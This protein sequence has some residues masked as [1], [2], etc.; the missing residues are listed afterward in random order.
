[1]GE[2]SPPYRLAESDP[3]N[4]VPTSAPVG[5]DRVV[6][7]NP[8]DGTVLGH[9]PRHGPEDVD[10]ACL[11]AQDML[12]ANLRGRIFP[13]HARA[14]TL[15]RAAALLEAQSDAFARLISSEAAKPITAARGEVARCIDTLRFSAAEARSLVGEMVPMEASE[16]GAGRLGFALRV[17]LGVIAAITPFNFPLNLVAHKVAPAIAAVLEELAPEA[18]LARMSGSGATCFALYADDAAR[19]RAAL[20]TRSKGWW[21]LATT[22]A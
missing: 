12:D 8:F 16:P 15:D 20:R 21:T 13:Q 19:D 10:R 4:T 11:A 17:P 9:V 1:M 22:L 18:I 6:V 7:H 5:D 2:N 3:V 14:A